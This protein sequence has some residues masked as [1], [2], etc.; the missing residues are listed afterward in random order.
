MK[1]HALLVGF[2]VAT[3]IG[4]QSSNEKNTLENHAGEGH[5]QHAAASET[6]VAGSNAA[7]TGGSE[8]FDESMQTILNSYLGIQKALAADSLQGVSDAAANIGKGV[9]QLDATSVTGEHAG[10]YKDVPTNLGQAATTLSKASDIKSARQAFKDL[11][12][13]MAMWGT[14]AKPQGIDVVY[15]PMA[16]GSW[17][18]ASGSIANPYH[19]SEMLTCG[20][21][22]GGAAFAAKAM[23][24][25][26]ADDAGHQH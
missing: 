17:L 13:P 10:H 3:V 2:S 25:K 16:K 8:K 20:E 18:Q 23:G 15:C 14:M 12:K 1:V 26:R 9:N 6:A 4:C 19:G 11:S 24:N 22:V 7:K 5:A 21:V